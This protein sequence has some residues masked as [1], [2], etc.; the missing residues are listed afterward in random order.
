[1]KN[2]R[3]P[4]DGLGSLRWADPAFIH[5]CRAFRSATERQ[6]EVAQRPAPAEWGKA[7]T[8]IV[9]YDNRTWWAVSGDPPEYASAIAYC[10]WCA[11]ELQSGEGDFRVGAAPRG[12]VAANAEPTAPLEEI[13]PP[14]ASSA[15][16]E[17]A[18][19]RGVGRGGVPINPTAAKLAIYLLARLAA[20]ADRQHS[21]ETMAARPQLRA[22]IA[23]AKELVVEV[24]GARSFDDAIQLV[25]RQ[26]PHDGTHV[27]A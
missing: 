8:T 1:M 17:E 26:Q 14:I 21:V 11:A 27:T 3:V 15:T 12:S 18:N 16:N 10:P 24:M 25:K 20:E 9:S 2:K 5:Q 23:A 7:I 4:D 13:P 22:L 6:A 19:D